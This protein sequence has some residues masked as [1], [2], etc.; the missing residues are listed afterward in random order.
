MQKSRHPVLK[1]IMNND[2]IQHQ[3]L[4]YVF[5]AERTITKEV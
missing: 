5:Y 2:R 1:N 4:E 3:R